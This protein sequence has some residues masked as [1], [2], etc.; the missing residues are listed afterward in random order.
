M[1]MGVQIVDNHG[2]IVVTLGNPR[3]RHVYIIGNLVVIPRDQLP[4][5]FL[6]KFRIKI[7]PFSSRIIFCDNTYV[8]EL[9]V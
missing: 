2:S 4:I 9:C 7:L 1:E 6:P 8:Y 3:K 5:D